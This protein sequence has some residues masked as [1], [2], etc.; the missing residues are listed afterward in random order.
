MEREDR[1]F[2]NV[3]VIMRMNYYSVIIPGFWYKTVVTAF[4]VFCYI[5]SIHFSDH[6]DCIFH[7]Q[8]ETYYCLYIYF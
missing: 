7:G 1:I 3:G 2:E 8:V 6:K 5:S 4:S